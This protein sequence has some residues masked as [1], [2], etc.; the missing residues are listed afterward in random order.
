[1]LS[2]TSSWVSPKKNP[3]ETS[4]ALAKRFLSLTRS[5]RTSLSASCNG[6]MGS[7]SPLIRGLLRYSVMGTLSNPWGLLVPGISDQV[8]PFAP[9]ILNLIYSLLS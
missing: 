2:S 8:P 3:L 1:M 4:M 9:S 5:L 6:R 7:K